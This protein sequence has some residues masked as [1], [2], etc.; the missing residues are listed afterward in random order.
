MTEATSP[1]FPR[2]RDA[3]R[4]PRWPLL[5]LAAI[6]LACAG[7]AQTQPGHAALRAVGLYEEPATYAELAFTAPS[8][9]PSTLAKPGARV[10]VS[11]G[12]HNVSAD[13][14]S[15]QWSIVLVHAGVSR[16]KASGVKLT[17]PE[18]RITITRSVTAACTGGR[19]QVVV[20]LASP[21]ESIGFWMTCPPAAVKK[22]GHQ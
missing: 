21:A 17:P 5:L 16:L 8:A 13:P 22:K 4:R 9:L 18:G 15:Y 3:T 19:V 14:R 11:F 2:G 10:K 6:V 20:R 12:V 7:L 1:T